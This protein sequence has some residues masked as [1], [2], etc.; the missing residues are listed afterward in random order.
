MKR[1]FDIFSSCLGLVVL[2][3]VLS[4]IAI[5]IF[6]SSGVPVLFRQQRVGLSGKEF[7]IYKFR[8]MTVDKDIEQEASFD[9]GNT[10]RVTKLGKLLRT[11]KLDELPQLVNVLKGEMSIVGPRTEIRKWVEVYPREWARVHSVRPGISDP[12]SIV[13]RHEEKILTNAENPQK[14]YRDMLLPKKLHLYQEY[15]DH[16]SFSYDIKL[17][18]LTLKSLFSR[19]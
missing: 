11:S 5:A 13:Y 8:T 3:P 12:A 17:I 9:A 4:A 16:A 19:G 2:S 18:L 14:M 15:V 7:T 6:L 10:A 1:F